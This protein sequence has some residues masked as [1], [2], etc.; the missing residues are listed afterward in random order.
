LALGLALGLLA[1]VLGGPRTAVA[2][3]APPKDSAATLAQML[4]RF[5]KKMDRLS[6]DIGNLTDEVQGVEAN[7]IVD[8]L[9]KEMRDAAIAYLNLNGMTVPQSALVDPL[10]QKMKETRGLVEIFK[11][12]ARLAGLAE[13]EMQDA[14]LGY[15]NLNMPFSVIG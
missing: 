15:L 13:E 7:I 10:E 9:E 8:P 5:D 1:V 11:N 3:E 12:R 4:K 6:R 2:V 14:A